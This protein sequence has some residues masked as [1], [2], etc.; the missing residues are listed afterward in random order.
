MTAALVLGL[1]ACGGDDAGTDGPGADAEAVAEPEPE[2]EPEPESESEPE[3]ERESEAEGAG[4]VSGEPAEP[5]TLLADELHPIELPEPGT[6]RVTLAGETY[7]FER[8]G[9]CGV[10]QIG[11]RSSFTAD[12][13]GELPDGSD[14]YFSL[15]RLVFDVDSIPTGQDHEWDLMQLAVEQESGG[16]MSSNAWHDT[17]RAMPGEPVRGDGDTL[18]VILVVDDGGEISA[19][20]VAEMRLSMSDLDRAGEGIGEFAVSC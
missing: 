17:A 6:A 9:A 3:P 4:E 15:N 5:A 16:G 1:A 13:F 7:V 20:A 14:L 11:E 19:T 18:P 2:P 12:G 10:S 8:L